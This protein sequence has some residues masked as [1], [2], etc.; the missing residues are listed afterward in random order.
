MDDQEDGENDDDD[1]EE[2]DDN[3]LLADSLSFVFITLIITIGPAAFLSSTLKRCPSQINMFTLSCLSHQVLSHHVL[4]YHVFFLPCFLPT[5]SLSYQIYKNF[6]HLWNNRLQIWPFNF[7][8]IK[9]FLCLLALFWQ[10]FEL[11][12]RFF[13]QVF[14]VGPQGWGWLCGAQQP[15]KGKGRREN[16]EIAVYNLSMYMDSWNKFYLCTHN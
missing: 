2:N 3:N 4:S 13:F 7:L 14:G 11:T 15:R 1:D 12:C 10:I 5:V 8:S 9:D 16:L 6:Q